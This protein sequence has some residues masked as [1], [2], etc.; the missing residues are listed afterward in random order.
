MSS[1]NG[2]VLGRSRR[3]GHTS[4]GANLGGFPMA[5]V[6]IVEVGAAAALIVLAAAPG[7][8]IVAALIMAVTLATGVFRWHGCWVPQWLVVIARFLVRDRRRAASPAPSVAEP[9]ETA[10]TGQSTVTGPED[11]RVALLRLL[12]EDLLVVSVTDHNQT[13]VGMAWHHGGWT[14]AL[15]IDPTPA[16]VSPV[17]ARTDLPLAALADCLHDRG[18]AL[19]A[20]GVIWHSYPASS[21]LPTSAPA[22]AAYNEVLGPLPAV[23]Q[24]STWVTVRLDARRCPQAVRERGGGVAG[25]HR[26]LLGAVSRVHGALELAGLNS[27][28]LSSDELLR[29]GVSSVELAATAGPSADVAL[30]EHWRGVRIGS[31]EHASY[32]ISAW[33]PEAGKLDALAGIRALS[34]TVAL[35]LTSGAEEGMV[36]LRGVVRIAARDSAERVAA[37]ATIG[38]LSTSSGVRLRAHNGGQA[39]AIAMTLP[40]S[41]AA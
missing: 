41:G 37:E 6:V 2:E 30:S 40:V 27:R 28:A 14:A 10:S 35:S 13:P 23:A 21:R 15:I 5:N 25:A 38:A 33:P 1:A 8:K 9:A 7:L 3:H 12:V 34:T 11:A 29:A 22:V 36:G 17:G 39:A 31:I 4:R 32:G 19:E 16:M 24:R 26:A 20:I 18:V